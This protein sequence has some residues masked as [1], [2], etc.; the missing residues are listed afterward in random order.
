MKLMKVTWIYP[1]TPSNNE[2]REL[3]RLMAKR[4]NLN[5]P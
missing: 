5:N 4:S 2:P 3:L 1:V